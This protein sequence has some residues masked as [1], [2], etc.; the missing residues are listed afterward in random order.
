MIGEEKLRE[1]GYAEAQIARLRQLS[2]ETDRDIDVSSGFIQ[3]RL[4]PSTV[5]GAVGL[6]VQGGAGGYQLLPSSGAYSESYV[7]RQSTFVSSQEPAPSVS[8][9]SNF[10]YDW[11]TKQLVSKSVFEQQQ[12]AKANTMAAL[13]ADV[14][15]HGVTV[16]RPEKLGMAFIGRQPL[17]VSGSGYSSYS[18]AMSGVAQARDSANRV[19][20]SVNQEI[21]GFPTSVSS[22]AEADFINAQIASKIARAQAVQDAVDAREA[23]VKAQY[24]SLYSAQQVNRE[25]FVSPEQYG[26]IAPAGG[27]MPGVSGRVETVSPVGVRRGIDVKKAFSPEEQQFVERFDPLTGEKYYSRER[28]EAA[29]QTEVEMAVA[30]TSLFLPMF[31]GGLAFGVP[32][33]AWGVAGLGA[34]YGLGAVSPGIYRAELRKLFP[35]KSEEV[36]GFSAEALGF[37]TSLTPF[38]AGGL[39]AGASV[40]KLAA[41]KTIW[42][43]EEGG[44]Q[45]FKTAGEYRSFWGLKKTPFSVSGMVVSD[46]EKTGLSIGAKGAGEKGFSFSIQKLLRQATLPKMKGTKVGL[47]GKTGEEFPESIAEFFSNQ[48]KYGT[49][50]AVDIPTGVTRQGALLGKKSK[51]EKLFGLQKSFVFGEMSVG[52]AKS[53]AFAEVYLSGG[54][55]PGLEKLGVTMKGASTGGAWNRLKLFGESRKLLPKQGEFGFPSGVK[56][57]FSMR[58]KILMEEMLTREAEFERGFEFIISAPKKE[59]K[60]LETI[61]GRALKVKE[62]IKKIGGSLR[63]SFT[64]PKAVGIQK[65]FGISIPLLGKQKGKPTISFIESFGLGEKEVSYG[66]AFPIKG[67]VTNETER[68]IARLSSG[69]PKKGGFKFIDV[70]QQA[71]KAG[72]IEK[73]FGVAYNEK[74][75]GVPS[76]KMLEAGIPP[77]SPIMEIG[78]KKQGLGANVFYS[79]TPASVKPFFN[80]QETRAAE[81]Q[82]VGATSLT[83]FLRPT[84]NYPFAQSFVKEVKLSAKAENGF[85]S[86][87]AGGTVQV[88]KTKTVALPKTKTFVGPKYFSNAGAAREKSFREF[89]LSPAEQFKR[90]PAILQ[91]L[92]EKE[93]FGFGYKPKEE[94]RS[95]EK[96][97]PIQKTSLLPQLK[98]KPSQAVRTSVRI[99]ER[100]AVAQKVSFAQATR[101]AS[102]LRTPA[103]TTTI[104]T[105]KIVPRIVPPPNYGWPGWFPKKGIFPKGMVKGTSLGFNVFSRKR[106]KEVRLNVGSLSRESALGL[107]SKFAR[108]TAARSFWISPSGG[109]GANVPG[110]K[111]WFKQGEFRRPKGKTRLPFQSFV[112]KSKYALNFPGEYREITLKGLQ[113]KRINRLLGKRKPRRR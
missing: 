55:K 106:G 23:R 24:P 30:G 73:T 42:G 65:S 33:A 82:S 49:N 36:Y 77:F 39:I 104:T 80:L 32:K 54:V 74:Q 99:G 27:L 7:P 89:S 72:K 40:P 96:M 38:A 15:A 66:K 95:L 46:L 47:I 60:F 17:N 21:A 10:V 64:V 67:K 28:L 4:D 53:T 58:E 83:A 112:E 22:Q 34:S 56:D 57:F 11:A 9:S 97:R 35:G 25:V 19:V 44:K 13:R 50:F 98:I 63:E 79:F 93:F 109:Y 48:A 43:V 1:L 88:L 2:K 84:K 8:S 61:G 3:S 37:A 70:S 6:R 92:T 5:Q 101:M 68:I 81:F 94:F 14:A 71:K 69:V 76:R 107:G 16:P 18:N 45:F 78:R 105:T 91:P 102:A 103:I 75:I 41:S 52:K 90:K 87:G 100:L 31:G 113:T 29:K 59:S 51:L 85:V 20:E 62:N 110:L 108:S 111:G 26:M 86:S 12:A